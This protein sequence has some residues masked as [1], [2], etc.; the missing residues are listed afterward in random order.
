LKRRLA[1]AERT[2]K[3]QASSQDFLKMILCLGITCYA[4]LQKVEHLTALPFHPIA[5]ELTSE[6]RSEPALEGQRASPSGLELPL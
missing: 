2:A 3:S 1:L 6:E 4:N 5:E